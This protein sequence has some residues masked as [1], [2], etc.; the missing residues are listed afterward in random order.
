MASS[1]AV[2]LFILTVATIALQGA[3]HWYMSKGRL[4]V[5]YPLTILAY[6]C[7]TVMETYLALRDPEQWSII[8]FVPMYLWAML[9]AAKGMWRL[10]KEKKDPSLKYVEL[11][12]QLNR[13]KK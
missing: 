6:F 9:M 2:F 3:N 10:H 12:K 13:G 4:N 11:Q 8:M 1:A 7:C 5:S